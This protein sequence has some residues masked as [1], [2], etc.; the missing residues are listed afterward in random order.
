MLMITEEIIR[1]A[2]PFLISLILQYFQGDQTLNID[3][4]LALEYGT[5]LCLCV[6]INA[7]IHHPAFLCNNLIGLKLRLSCS[8]LIYKKIFKYNFCGKESEVSGRVM[9]LISNDCNQSFLT[10]NLCFN[11]FNL[12]NLFILKGGRLELVT[13]FISY[14]VIGPLQ[15]IF[16]IAV[17]IKVVDKHF[18]T[19]LGVMCIFVPSQSIISKLIDHLRFVCFYF[20][21]V[22]ILS[23]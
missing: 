13:L 4:T 6:F 21:F 14:L 3:L 11:L 19:G 10:K 1:M 20:I 9:N 16:V 5:L 15:A 17:L 12:R 22:N 8:G 18:L 7:T 23:S 2:Q